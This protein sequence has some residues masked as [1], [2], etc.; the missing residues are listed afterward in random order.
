ME[1]SM[2][3]GV[4]GPVIVD[5]ADGGGRGVARHSDVSIARPAARHLSPCLVPARARDADSG[6]SKFGG[7]NWPATRVF[8]ASGDC[9]FN[10]MT[11]C[12]MG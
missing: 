11:V 10:L 12:S 6:A 2:D 5:G 9:V 8:S 4:G 1:T 7:I 3:S